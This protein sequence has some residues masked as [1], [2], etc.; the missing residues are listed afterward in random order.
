MM[1]APRG[2]WRLY[3]GHGDPRC[4]AERWLRFTVRTGEAVAPTW[5]PSRD[6]TF[7]T[8]TPPEEPMP[9]TL[10]CPTY[11][12]SAAARGSEATD[13]ASRLQ[14]LVGRR[15]GRVYTRRMIH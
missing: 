2:R 5:A 9:H 11:Q 7:H 1:S 3:P 6:I 10:V 13:A 8:R 14:R 12:R 4:D 15:L